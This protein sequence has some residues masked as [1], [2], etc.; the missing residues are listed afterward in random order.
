MIRLLNLFRNKGVRFWGLKATDKDV[1]LKISLFGC[2]DALLYA[3]EA[4]IQLTV[5]KRV[6]LPFFIH[7]YRGRVGLAVGG[8]MALTMI[9]ASLFFV[10][11]IEITGNDRISAS[12]I[13]AVLR[14]NGLSAGA[15]IP[16]V[17]THAV[18]EHT[19]LAMPNLSSVAIVITG[20]HVKVDVIER[21]RPPEIVDEIGDGISSI[22][23]EK[24]GIIVSVVAESGKSLVA[25]GTVV[26]AGDVLVTGL[27]DGYTGIKIAVKSKATVL[28]QTYRNFAISVPLRQSRREYTGGV[29]KKTTAEV[30]GHSF[31]LYFGAMIPFEQFD[32]E[33]R[34]EDVKLFGIFKTPIRLTTLTAREY[35]TVTEQITKE[36][37]L[38]KAVAAFDSRLEEIDDGEILDKSYTWFFDEESECV[39]LTGKIT[40]LEDIAVERAIENL[41]E[42]AD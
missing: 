13:E 22:Y 23:A 38:K 11:D 36:E 7:R 33:A 12:R 5:E 17:N 29:S 30:L 1:R 37:A 32:A 10:W 41:N 31:E 21:I 27:Y 19:I 39:T 42:N 26:A 16:S 8:A 2:D 34:T 14:K 20:T 28:A 3:K 35:R 40:L 18:E 6:G 4:N 9:F 25:P 24:D 15:F